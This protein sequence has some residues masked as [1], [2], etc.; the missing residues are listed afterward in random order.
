MAIILGFLILASLIQS[1]VFGYCVVIP[2]VAWGLWTITNLIVDEAEA[3][4]S[5]CE[6]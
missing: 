4:K 3:R 2:V 5:G 1:E 6:W